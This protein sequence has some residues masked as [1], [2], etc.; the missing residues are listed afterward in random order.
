MRAV[1]LGEHGAEIAQLP[2]PAPGPGQVLVRVRA[3]CLNRA[4]LLILNG[5][6]HGSTGG[7]GARLGLEWAGEVEALGDGVEGLNVGDR[8]MGSGG[9]AFAD[10]LFG[11]PPALYPV[12]VGLSFE[13]AACLPVGLQTIQDAIVTNGKL[14]PGQSLLV[15]G[16]SSGMGLMALQVAKLLGAGIVIGTS[17][18]AQRRAALAGFGADLALD[19]RQA[20]WVDQV[21]EATNGTGVDLAIDFLAGPLINDTMRAV[22]LGGRIVNVGRMAGEAGSFDFDLH[23]LRRITYTGVTFRTR[24][25]AEVMAVIAAARSA[26]LPALKQGKLTMPVD[27]TF[28]LEQAAEA[29]ARMAANTHFG[30]IVLTTN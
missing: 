30:K 11:F 27:S 4:D 18:N 26:L 20:D 19:T 15:Q 13:Q 22:R 21:L 7:M 28:P 24:T 1:V 16:A 14:E 3:A 5:A 17:T 10:Y 25:L 8:V 2:K 9:G 23:S 6:T 29:F 12:P